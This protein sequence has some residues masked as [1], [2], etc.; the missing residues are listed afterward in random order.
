MKTQQIGGIMVIIAALA[1]CA[2]STISQSETRTPPTA[3]A[4]FDGGVGFGSGGR[5]QTD[6]T[7]TSSTAAD[8]GAVS[9]TCGVGFGSGGR[10]E[11]CSSAPQ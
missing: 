5:T 9:A 8:T 4:A 3:G 7:G 10:T 6:S 2:D 1:A 11:D